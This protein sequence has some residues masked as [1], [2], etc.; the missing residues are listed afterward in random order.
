[1][2]R[3]Y[4]HLS[5]WSV[6]IQ[7]PTPWQ[8]RYLQSFDCSQSWMIS[9][10]VSPSCPSTL[11]AYATNI[12]SLAWV[13]YCFSEDNGLA[14]PIPSELGLLT[15]LSIL[16]FGKSFLLFYVVRLCYESTLIWLD[17]IWFSDANALTG[18]IPS[19]LRLLTK[20][21]RLDLGKS[22]LSFYVDHLSY[23]RAHLPGWSFGF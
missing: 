5:G 23:E 8:A 16:D 20:L 6:G 7:N 22:F 18:P 11:F 3:I 21:T 1:M 2:L 4:T 9:A 12:R 19:E 17:D 13:I 10:W 15:E 14:G